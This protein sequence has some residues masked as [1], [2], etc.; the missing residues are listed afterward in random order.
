M[1]IKPVDTTAEKPAPRLNDSGQEIPD[2]TPIVLRVKNRLVTNFDEIRAFMRKELSNY[3]QSQG[4]E[5]YD[6][7]NDFDIDDDPTDP[8]TPWEEWGDRQAEELQQ[9]VKK[10]QEENAQLRNFYQ[11]RKRRQQQLDTERNQGKPSD[12]PPQDPPP[13]P[14]G[15]AKSGTPG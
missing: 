3:A 2:D 15:T 14:A 8:T 7:A 1:A 12:A 10:R 9:T 4:Q 6:E 11:R 5:S 13:V